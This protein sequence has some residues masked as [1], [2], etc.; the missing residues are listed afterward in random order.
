[1]RTILFTLLTVFICANAVCAGSFTV[2]GN[3]TITDTTTNLMWQQCTYGLSDANCATGA[4][5]TI[6]WEASIVYC[7]ALSLA[8]FTDWRLPNIKELRTIV[9][10]TT[11]SPAINAVYF[12]NTDLSRYWSSTSSAAD[13]AAAL[14][15]NFGLGT[16]GGLDKTT[17]YSVRCVR[18][19]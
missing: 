14:F 13:T 5:S 17:L 12:P 11:H 6:T 15:V 8:G 3:G 4:A 16:A 2:S 10:S 9:D 19:Q 1:M 18:G 7:E